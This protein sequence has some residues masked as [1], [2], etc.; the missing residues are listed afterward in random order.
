MHVNM[1]ASGAGA[2]IVLATIYNDRRWAKPVGY[3][4]GAVLL[5][6]LVLGY[7]PGSNA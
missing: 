2:A 4:G 3:L 7:G 1:I 6:F 5:A